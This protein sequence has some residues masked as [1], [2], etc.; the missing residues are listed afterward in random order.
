MEGCCGHG[1]LFLAHSRC[2]GFWRYGGRC[3]NGRS[4]WA[5]IRK[6][7]ELREILSVL[8]T[9]SM[10]KMLLTITTGLVLMAQAVNATRATLTIVPKLAVFAQ[11]WD[12]RNTYLWS[13]AS[14]DNAAG[15]EIVVPAFTVEFADWIMV[16]RVGTDV[17]QNG[18]VA[19]YYGLGA[20]RTSS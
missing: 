4:Y 18:C 9:G 1:S 5:G 8:K 7:G 15:A 19:D 16:K 12:T 13:Q 11:E 6:Y 17:V 10:L 14:L 3:I 20:I 2:Y